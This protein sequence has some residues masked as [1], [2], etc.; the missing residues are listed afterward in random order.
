MLIVFQ[1]IYFVRN[2]SIILKPKH[3]PTFRSFDD[4]WVFLLKWWYC[5]WTK[6]CTSSKGKYPLTY[7][8]FLYILGRCFLDFWTI[9]SRI[10]VESHQEHLLPSSFTASPLAATWFIAPSWSFLASIPAEAFWS[11]CGFSQGPEFG[12]L[13]PGNLTWNLKIMDFPFPGTYFQ[14]PC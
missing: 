14:V 2:R 8:V 1:F 6:S 5:W 13:H 10:P 11:N 3:P 9:N 7:R 12:R 4:I